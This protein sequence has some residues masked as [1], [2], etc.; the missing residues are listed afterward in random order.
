MIAAVGG[1]VAA[2]RTALAHVLFNLFTGLVAVVLLPVFM[3]VLDFTRE[4]F[5]WENG[6]LGLAAF[7][8]SFIL[9]GVLIFLPIIGPFSRL[10][11]R[12]LPE[13]SLSLTR[14]LDDSLL[15]L[16]TVAMEATRVSLRESAALL[17][18]ILLRSLRDEVPDRGT[19]EAVARIERSLRETSGFITR[20]PPVEHQQEGI[21]LRRDSFHAID[22]LSQLLPYHTWRVSHYLGRHA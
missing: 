2:K 4:S 14:H 22:H 16:P 19:E 17:M 12:F 9:I 20:I 18:E 8:T 13:K 6:A 15:T 7:H 3:R 10:I 21:Q 1:S 5:G 11:E